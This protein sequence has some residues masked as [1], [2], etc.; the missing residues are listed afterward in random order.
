FWQSYA[1]TLANKYARLNKQG[2]IKG[3]KKTKKM[4]KAYLRGKWSMAR[5][6]DERGRLP[7]PLWKKRVDDV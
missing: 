4:L 3:A 5:W 1:W 2:D 6:L 7:Y